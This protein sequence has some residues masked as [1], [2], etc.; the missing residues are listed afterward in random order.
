M[1]WWKEVA[2]EHGQTFAPQG[3]RRVAND[4]TLR[5]L[6]AV[7]YRRPAV[8]A[9]SRLEFHEREVGRIV[10]PVFAHNA[11]SFQ[12]N[13]WGIGSIS[14]F[15]VGYGAIPNFYT[16]NSLRASARR[17]R[18][19]TIRCHRSTEGQVPIIAGLLLYAYGIY[20]AYI[21][22]GLFVMIYAVAVILATL[23]TP[24]IKGV[25]LES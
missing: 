13:S 8:S 22:I 17:A 18:A 12:R 9:P 24:E 4:K 15:S 1:K 19:P 14:L 23:A 6:A 11:D 3:N 7:A 25:D 21:H 10:K 2:P 5:A 20:R 16:E